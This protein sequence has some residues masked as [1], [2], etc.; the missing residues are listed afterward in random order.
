MKN[1]IQTC[2]LSDAWLHLQII[3]FKPQKLTLAKYTVQYLQLLVK[4]S[5]C[6]K[7]TVQH[8]H[9]KTLILTIT[10]QWGHT[11]NTHNN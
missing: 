7:F 11:S 4:Y 3:A 8:L 9:G 2:G 6:V 1:K 5:V 10:L